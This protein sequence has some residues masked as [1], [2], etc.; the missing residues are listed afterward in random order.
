M[1]VDGAHTLARLAAFKYAPTFDL[2]PKGLTITNFNCVVTSLSCGREFDA[3]NSSSLV[4]GNLS[5]DAKR[6]ACEGAVTLGELLCLSQDFECGIN[7]H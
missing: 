6:L 3:K 5:S 1:N 7:A 4:F 2:M